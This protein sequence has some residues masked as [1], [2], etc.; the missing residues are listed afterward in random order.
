MSSNQSADR[1]YGASKYRQQVRSSRDEP[2]LE[3]VAC[4]LHRFHLPQFERCS[5]RQTFTNGLVQ[6]ASSHS[7][8][9]VALDQPGHGGSALHLV[10]PEDCDD[11]QAQNVA[12][13]TPDR[14]A[15]THLLHL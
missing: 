9:V 13:Q 15:S 1:C 11:L 5:N 12:P 3:A 10:P 4:H 8:N 6:Q 14:T 7:A 2:A